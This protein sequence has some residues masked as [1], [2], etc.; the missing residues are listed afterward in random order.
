MVIFQAELCTTQLLLPCVNDSYRNGVKNRAK[1]VISNVKKQPLE[2][3]E[4][5]QIYVKWWINNPMEQIFSEVS[6]LL[7]MKHKETNIVL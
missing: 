7:K 4:A 3:Q 2:P 5:T 1:L 6:I